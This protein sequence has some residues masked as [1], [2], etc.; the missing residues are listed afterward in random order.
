MGRATQGVRLIRLGENDEIS[1]V[2][3]LRKIEE[4][5]DDLTTGEGDDQ[6]SDQNN[7]THEPNNLD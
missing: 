3:R 2:E 1:S 5:E 7:Q 4:L 6:D